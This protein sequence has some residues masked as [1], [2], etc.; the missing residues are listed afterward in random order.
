MQFT[1]VVG[2]RFFVFILLYGYGLFVRILRPSTTCSEIHPP[3]HTRMGS[4]QY[5]CVRT[6]PLV[7]LSI[8][9]MLL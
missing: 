5:E 1:F 8:N 6:R 3:H 2:V 7:L 9:N 4:S